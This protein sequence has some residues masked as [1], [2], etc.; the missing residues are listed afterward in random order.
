MFGLGEV[1]LVLAMLASLN[2]L[3]YVGVSCFSSLVLFS[4]QSY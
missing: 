4:V 3:I 1:D 2:G